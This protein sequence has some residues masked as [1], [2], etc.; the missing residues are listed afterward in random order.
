M[1]W[2]P[3]EVALRYQTLRESLGAIHGI[4]PTTIRGERCA[5][6]ARLVDD[7]ERSV[8]REIRCA[9]RLRYGYDRRRRDPGVDR[10][11][12]EAVRSAFPETVE[13]ELAK[14]GLTNG[15]KTRIWIGRRE[16][17]V[18]GACFERAAKQHGYE[19]AFRITQPWRGVADRSHRGGVT[20]SHRADAVEDQV[21]GRLDEWL[22]L[23]PLME[24]VAPLVDGSDWWAG[25]EALILLHGNKIENVVEIA[26]EQRLFPGPYHVDRVDRCVR[27]VRHWIRRRLEAPRSWLQQEER[28][29]TPEDSVSLQEAAE[30]LGCSVD[31]VRKA[32]LPGWRDQRLA[33]DA[34]GPGAAVAR[35]RVAREAVKA[36]RARRWGGTENPD[37]PDSPDAEA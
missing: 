31:H 8:R 17:D 27:L 5:R 3:A 1:R 20:T 12:K 21:L 7:V 36:E 14:Q 15:W 13:T 24:V 25:R 32:L 37:N 10:L 30:L 35:W 2:T 9:A 18:C 19:E 11:V 34:R 4:D 22:F 23:R 28:F 33:I 29:M 26:E 6:C 16:K